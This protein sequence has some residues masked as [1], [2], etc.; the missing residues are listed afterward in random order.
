MTRDRAGL[1]ALRWGVRL[2]VLVL[3]RWMFWGVGGVGVGVMRV[4]GVERE[5]LRSN[6]RARVGPDGV[7]DRSGPSTSA[8]DFGLDG[9]GGVC[10]RRLSVCS[11]RLIPVLI[12]N[13]A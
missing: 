10:W 6:D 13:L 9:A 1:A 4:A 5:D 12:R 7:G 8:R 11:M 2:T 3:G